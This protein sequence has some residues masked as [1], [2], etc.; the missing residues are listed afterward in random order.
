MKDDELR[1][2]LSVLE[3][4]NSQLE[5]F[6]QQAQIFRMSLEEAL[7]ARETMK[8]FLNAKEGDEIL[9]PIGASS[10]VAAKASGD[11]KAIVG[12]G[13]KISVEKDLADAVK[14]LDETVKDISDALKK[15]SDNAAEME[16]NARNLSL[17]VQQE[18]QRRQQ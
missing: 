1:Q 16:T 14:Y 5:A 9:V 8:A 18:Y 6:A 13:S 12:I 15:T 11:G 4:Y 17:A 2:S 10:F 7:R 3:A